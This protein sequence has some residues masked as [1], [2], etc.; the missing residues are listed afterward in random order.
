MALKNP[1]KYVLKPQREGGG[2]NV[3]R[4]E[5]RTVFFNY[6]LLCL[7]RISFN[8]FVNKLIYLEL[9][10]INYKLK[11]YVRSLGYWPSLTGFRGLTSVCQNTSV[12]AEKKIV[13]MLWHLQ[14]GEVLT[15]NHLGIITPLFKCLVRPIFS[16]F[17]FF[18][19]FWN[20]SEIPK[21][22]KHTSLWIGFFHLFKKTILFVY[23]SLSNWYRW[24]LN[25]ASLALFLGKSS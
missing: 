23:M 24:Y 15:F 5:I 20:G 9:L 10:F 8:W 4:D 19:R 2:N 22:E 14:T 25:L 21:R 11:S 3:F 17:F 7:E 13:D 6:S 12:L 18:L 16:H 1:E